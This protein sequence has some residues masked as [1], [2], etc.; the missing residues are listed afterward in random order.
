MQEVRID[1]N[2]MGIVRRDAPMCRIITA[3]VRPKP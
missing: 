2:K 3:M 1:A